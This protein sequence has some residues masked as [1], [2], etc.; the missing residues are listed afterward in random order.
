MNWPGGAAVFGLYR[1]FTI[2]LCYVPLFSTLWMYNETQQ[3]ID[4]QLS[5]HSGYDSKCKKLWAFCS[6]KVWYQLPLDVICFW[7][8]W[9]LFNILQ[10]NAH[11]IHCK[12][13]LLSDLW[14]SFRR[15]SPGE[16]PVAWVWILTS[17]TS[18]HREL[19]HPET[20][21]KNIWIYLHKDKCQQH[22]Y[23][24]EISLKWQL[25]WNLF[26]LK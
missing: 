6:N 24:W 10:T 25:N 15:S 18:I 11:E 9:W 26:S 2:D 21:H 3:A 19:V 23:R 4:F 5:S 7:L 17:L 12:Q 14:G 8:V 20:V 13:F 16:L 1:L 22:Q